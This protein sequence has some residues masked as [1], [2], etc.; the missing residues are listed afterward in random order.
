MSGAQL[1]QQHRVQRCK[2]QPHKYV[3]SKYLQKPLN[4]CCRFKIAVNCSAYVMRAA[5][6]TTA[7]AASAQAAA[8]R[9]LSITSQKQQAPQASNLLLQL[10]ASSGHIR[11]AT[12]QAQRACCKVCWGSVLAATQWQQH[13][14]GFWSASFTRQQLVSASTR[15]LRHDRA[16]MCCCVCCRY[17]ALASAS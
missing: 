10:G 17:R 6:R 2:A 9:I 15:A 11:A 13:S 14:L 1:E 8:L 7:A 3:L 4:M 5:S 16:V 12:L